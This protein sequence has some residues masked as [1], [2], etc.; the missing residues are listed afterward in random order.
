MDLHLDRTFKYYWLMFKRHDL[1]AGLTV[2]LVA[3]P[4]CLGVAISFWSSTLFRNF[5][6]N[7]RWNCS[8]SSE[9]FRFSC[10]WSCCR[11][12]YGCRCL[13]H[14]SWRFSNIFINRYYRWSIPNFIRRF[15]T[16]RFC[17]L[18]PKFCD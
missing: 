6:R 11:F 16:R 13:Y 7:Y 12:N 1:S 8:R 17:Q 3:L 15:K 2:F 4:L 18:F 10:F 5:I 14:Q 9:W